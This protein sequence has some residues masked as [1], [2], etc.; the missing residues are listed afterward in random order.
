M[1]FEDVLES[2]AG[3][4]PT[5]KIKIDK[6]DIGIM[7]SIAKQTYNNVGLTDRQ[8]NVVKEKLELYKDQIPNFKQPT[9]LRIPLREIDRRH[10]V[11]LEERD[12]KTYVVIKFPFKKKLIDLVEGIRMLM[13]EK[14]IKDKQ[15]HYFLLSEKS[16]YEV[17]KLALRFEAFEIEE[18]LLD[19]YKEL[20]YIKENQDEYIPYV[21][22]NTAYNITDKCSDA[23][24]DHCG[25]NDTLLYYDR[26]F[27]FGIKNFDAFE[28]EQRM[29][30]MSTLTQKI[31]QRKTHDLFLNSKTWTINQ[32]A[33]TVHE[34][35]RYPLLVVLNSTT[36]HDELMLVHNA[37]NGF[38]DPKE[39]SVVFRKDNDTEESK[40]F[41]QYIKDNN[42]NNTVDNNT[43][44]VYTSKDKLPKPLI[45]LGFRHSCMLNLNSMR[46]NSKVDLFNEGNDL[47]IVYSDEESMI[48]RYHAKRETI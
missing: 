18:Q 1:T 38:I 29:S 40:N 28:V 19:W 5:H 17:V 35:N 36:A 24:F 47:T 9:R 27:L 12:E 22:N 30:K 10:Y 34:L 8:L 21:K 32:L 15:K 46:T 48:S 7:S 39:C 26:R 42:L 2:I 41:N 43:K 6:S 37:F 11:A 23:L 45:E 44:I 4:K 14:H 16:V 33:E 3:P 31:L 20:A 25:T 13:P